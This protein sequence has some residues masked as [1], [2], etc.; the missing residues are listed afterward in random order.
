MKIGHK[1]LT[2]L[3]LMGLKIS[4]FTLWNGQSECCRTYKGFS[5]VV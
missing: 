2:S 4:V 5:K 3:G 1:R